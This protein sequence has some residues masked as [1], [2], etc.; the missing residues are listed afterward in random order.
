MESWAN[1]KR[2]EKCRCERKKDDQKGVM[3][4]SG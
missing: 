1:V 4:K 2:D 3:G